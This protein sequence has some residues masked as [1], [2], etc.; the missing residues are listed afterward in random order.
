MKKLFKKITISAAVCV[1]LLGY[2]AAQQASF[3]T[4]D[5]VKIE[6]SDIVMT[7]SGETKFHAFKISNPPR[8]IVEFTNTEHNWKQREIE[9][10]GKV[11]KRVRSGQFQNEPS[12]IARVVVD[13]V[14]LPEY[15]L[16]GKGNIVTLRIGAE[17][18]AGSA[19][20]AKAVPAET[21]AAPAAEPAPVEVVA[22]PLEAEK[23]DKPIVPAPKKEE[24][25]KAVE[26]PEVPKP[27]A[28]K[29]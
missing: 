11:I 9:L 27:V 6:G 5:N 21:A 3:V 25:P 12:K 28:A 7:L 20:D 2:I 26:K 8:L 14:K 10:N 13:L 17:P 18:A 1:A 15:S 4:L 22:Q 23:T 19:D 29:A 16:N 24:A